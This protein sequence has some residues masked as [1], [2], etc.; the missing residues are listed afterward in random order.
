MDKNECQNERVSAK[1]MGMA[2]IAVSILL[3]TI[4]WVLVPVV[5]FVFAVP[6]LVLGL[7]LIIAPESKTC[8][9]IIEGLGG[10]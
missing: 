7:G 8:R 10:R 2:I 5:G 9:M 3:L 4:G 1:T 6:L